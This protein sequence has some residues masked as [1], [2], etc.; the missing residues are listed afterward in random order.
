MFEYKREMPT[1]T[2]D[3]L[4]WHV[5]NKSTFYY[6][7]KFLLIKRKKDPF[8]DCWALPGGHFEVKSDVNIKNAAVRELQEETGIITNNDLKFFK[9]YDEIDR[10]PRGRY[11]NF[12]FEALVLPDTKVVPSDDAI[13]FCWLSEA[14]VY[15]ENI[16]FD[17][18]KIISDFVQYY[19]DED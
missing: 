16:A 4:C 17:H 9:Y 6:D 1:I 5:Y 15:S 18:K 3:V 11:I 14:E 2:A 7:L 12:V 10:D 19:F 8:K 13:D